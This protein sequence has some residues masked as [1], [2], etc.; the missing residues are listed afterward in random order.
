MPLFGSTRS[1]NLISWVVFLLITYTF[2]NWF[3]ETAYIWYTGDTERQSR[4]YN[5]YTTEL[6]E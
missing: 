1:D 4:L 2:V 6:E 3:V 5:L